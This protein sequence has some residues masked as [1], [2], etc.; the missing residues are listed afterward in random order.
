MS[1]DEAAKRNHVVSLMQSEILD[2]KSQRIREREKGA[3]SWCKKCGA[4]RG[5]E[6]DCEDV[7]L[8]GLAIALKHA[9]QQI[10]A[11]KKQASRYYEDLLKVTGKLAMVK[12]EN[13][14]L[15]AANK[16][17]REEKS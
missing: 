12:H 17:L 13:N 11:A 16:K 8:V 4:F 5:H 14:K 2:S 1:S 3:Y 6:I 9:R 10:D 7:D 15:R